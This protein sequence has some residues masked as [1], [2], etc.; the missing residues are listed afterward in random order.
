MRAVMILFSLG[1]HAAAGAPSVVVRMAEPRASHGANLLEDGTVLVTGGFRKAADGH[2]QLYARTTEVFDPRTNKV[3]AGPRM[4]HARSGHVTAM[5]SDSS[6]LVA[7][8]WGEHG[9]LRS[10][11]LFE[12]GSRRFV[13]LGE[14]AA[15]RGGA[16][17]TRLADGRVVVI[18]GGDDRLLLATIEMYD[19]ATRSW[20]AAGALTVPRSGHTATLLPDGRVLVI[21]GATAAQQVVASAEL[22]DPRS[23]RAAPVGAMAVARYKHAAMLLAGGDVLVIGGSDAR[24]WRGKH[25]TTELYDPRTGA[26]RPGPRLTEPRFKIPRAVVGLAN[27]DVVIVG[28]APS[29]EVLRDGKSH[30]LGA[31][32]GAS[33]F[34]T[35]TRLPSDELVMIGGYD[36]KLQASPTIR[37]I[38]Q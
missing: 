10:A 3:V 2:S 26:F 8:G 31:L 19:P 14:L 37:R 32:D 35:A 30:T 29:I 7:G 20:R 38:K 6:V 24:D 21:G 15:P 25:A 11:E 13:E 1:C 28:G 27:G 17:A 18:G 36:D 23:Q 5:L 34:A 22:Y 9:A 33:Y 16:T 4:H 12:P